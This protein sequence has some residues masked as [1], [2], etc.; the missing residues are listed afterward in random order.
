MTH[1]N[2]LSSCT[3]IKDIVLTREDSIISYLPYPH[4]FEQ[5]LFFYGNYVG[6][7]TGF[8]QGDPLKL[9]ED[10]AILKPALFPSV[11]RLW[12]RIYAKI[13]SNI[14]GLT[15]CKGWLAQTALATK[16]AA[17]VVDGSYT[18][19]C[20]D[21]LVFSKVKMILGGNVRNMITASAPIDAAVI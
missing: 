13:K 21:A 19:G 7:K 11:P 16:L 14:D 15:G 5:C 1:R 3:Q 10:L 2:L 4:S 12:N 9:T 17:T 18:H 8:Y 6:C 20:Y